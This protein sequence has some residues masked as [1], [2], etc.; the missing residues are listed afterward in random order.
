MKLGA[1]VPADDNVP[2]L[3]YQLQAAANASQVD[4]R[5]LSLTSTGAS[6]P[7]PDINFAGCQ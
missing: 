3:I 7:A 2:S 1:A 4:F 6:T 5:D